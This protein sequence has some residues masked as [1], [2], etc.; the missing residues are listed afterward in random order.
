MRFLFLI[1]FLLN[2]CVSKLA[3]NP[4]PSKKTQSQNILSSDIEPTTE[5]IVEY[6]IYD[7]LFYFILLLILVFI[8]S[9]GVKYIRK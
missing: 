3:K 2:G 6:N 5:S 9:V 1:L 4:P 8:L 7:P